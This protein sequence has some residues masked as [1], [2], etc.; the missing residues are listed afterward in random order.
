M[1]T[2]RVLFVCMW[3]AVVLSACGNGGKRNG[4][5]RITATTGMIANMAEQI[6]GQHVEVQSLMGPGVDPHLYKP[7]QGDLSRLAD[8]DIV[9][10]NGLHLEGKMTEVLQKMSK[11]QPVFAVSDTLSESQLLRVPGGAFPDPHIWHDAS[12]WKQCMWYMAGKMAGFDPV[13]AQ[14]YMKNAA[15]LAVSLDS[16]HEEVKARMA[17]IPADKRI[18]VTSHD[19]FEYY[20]RAYGV[21]VRGLQGISTVA[22]PGIRDVNDLVNFITT[23]RIRTVFV[24]SSVSPRLMESVTEGCRNKGWNVSSGIILY[25]DAL[26]QKNTP[27]GTYEGMLRYNSIEISQGLQ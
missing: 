20:G 4:K 12:L 18:L 13:N 23:H 24:E 21:K 6:G 17:A 14:E 19:A 16:L 3:L 15:L 25:S 26:G 1:K 10:H 11:T 22:E 2:T 7:T 27:E 8:A 5:L 9:F